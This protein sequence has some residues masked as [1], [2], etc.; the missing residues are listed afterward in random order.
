M[1][2]SGIGTRGEKTPRPFARR[3][4]RPSRCASEGWRLQRRRRRR[5][6]VRRWRRAVRRPATRR[7]WPWCSR[8]RGGGGGGG[9]AAKAKGAVARRR[10]GGE[11]SYVGR[12]PSGMRP[13]IPF[14]KSASHAHER[15]RAR[16]PPGYS[17]PPPRGAASAGIEWFD[18]H[19]ADSR[20]ASVP[21]GSTAPAA[22]TRARGRRHRAVGAPRG[23]G[24]ASCRA[25]HA[26]AGAAPTAARDDGAAAES[27]ANRPGCRPVSFASASNVLCCCFA[28]SCARRPQC[29]STCRR[30]R[31]R[32]RAGE[33]VCRRHRVGGVAEHAREEAL[34]RA[35]GAVCTRH[36]ARSRGR[37]WRSPRELSSVGRRSSGT[38]ARP[39]Q[40]TRSPPV[41]APLRC[42][43]ID[44]QILAHAP[45]HSPRALCSPCTALARAAIACT[46]RSPAQVCARRPT[47]R[48]ITAATPLRRRAAAR[49]HPRR[50]AFSAGSRRSR[51]R[52]CST[53]AAQP[54]ARAALKQMMADNTAAYPHLAD[55]VRGI[56]DGAADAAPR[57]VGRDAD[58]RARVVHARP[59]TAAR[60]VAGPPQRRLRRRR[61]RTATVR[62]RRASMAAGRGPA[63]CTTFTTTW[64][65]RAPASPAPGSCAGL[66]ALGRARRLGAARNAHGIYATQNSLFPECVASARPRLRPLCSATRCAARRARAGST[67]VERRGRRARAAGR[68]APRSTS[69]RR[70]GAAD[71]G[72]EAHVDE[73]VCAR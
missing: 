29:R 11:P 25:L 39:P 31:C 24:A 4:G 26:A 67:A 16:A 56:S 32:A 44:V 8:E 47:W 38:R 12:T 9:G 55:E 62:C 48:K 65:R 69:S 59:A 70:A 72:F 17:P 10:S 3:A 23:A 52:R 73:P 43:N 36:F 19:A 53:T 71:G 30:C 54:P 40:S 34:L 15:P 49:R 35:V 21:A 6:R 64:R 50:T 2:V 66:I 37:R 46:A 51:C 20:P 42:H 61:R 63:R 13:G 33:E 28:L 5:R 60:P 22:S 58:Q 7:R 41:D 14:A 45:L 1:T 57:R 68:R 18:H 27:L